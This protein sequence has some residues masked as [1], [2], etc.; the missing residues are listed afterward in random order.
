MDLE[1]IK[2]KKWELVVYLLF[3]FFIDF[4]KDIIRMKNDFSFN[5]LYFDGEKFL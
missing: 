3:I 5:Y 1:V 4:L 2:Y